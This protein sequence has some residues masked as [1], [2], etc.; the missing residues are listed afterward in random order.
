MTVNLHYP[1]PSSIRE[2]L[3]F[4]E[5]F[6]EVKKIQEDWE[7]GEISYLLGKGEKYLSFIKPNDKRFLD[8]HSQRQ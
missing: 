5:E 3:K 8:T 1:P 7:C 4:E 2:K 6:N